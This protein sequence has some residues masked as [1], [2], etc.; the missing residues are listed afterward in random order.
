MAFKIHADK[1]AG[2]KISPSVQHTYVC[3]VLPKGK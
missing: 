1:T 2:I 3:K